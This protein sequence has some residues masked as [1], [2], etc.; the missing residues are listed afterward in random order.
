[1]NEKEKG[2][3]KESEN[4]WYDIVKHKIVSIFSLHDAT[5]ATAISKTSHQHGAA[6]WNKSG[7]HRSYNVRVME[8]WHLSWHALK[9]I[10]VPVIKFRGTTFYRLT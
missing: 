1:M 8:M 3:M 10:C 9:G 5:K 7:P 4:V 6:A 2:S